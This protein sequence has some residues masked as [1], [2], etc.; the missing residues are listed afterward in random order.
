MRQPRM[1]R[2]ARCH[3]DRPVGPGRDDAVDPQRAHEPLDRRLVLGRE[4][5]AP[6]GEREPGRTGIA[7][8][9]GDPQAART[10]C[11]EQTELSGPRS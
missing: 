2:D 7:I 6:V 8:D 11:L 1:L 3:A 10:R 5:A 4:D 9:H